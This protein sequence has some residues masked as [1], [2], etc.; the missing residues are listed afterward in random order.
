VKDETFILIIQKR[1]TQ[2]LTFSIHSDLAQEGFIT[3]DHLL[4]EDVLAMA[5]VLFHL[6]DAPMHAEITNTLNPSNSLSPCRMC[7]LQVTQKV[8]KESIEFVRDFLALDEN[9]LKVFF[10]LI[11]LTVCCARSNLP[12]LSCQFMP[13]PRNWANT[14]LQSHQLWM[15]GQKRH[16]K[17]LY[18]DMV[19]QYGLRDHINDYF[20][21]KVQVAH[22]T[23]PPHEV[24]ALVQQLDEDL[25][26]RLFNPML[27][28]KGGSLCIIN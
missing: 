15:S 21:K 5:V 26:D 18:E 16:T 2:M 10:C 13:P 23:Q 20:I 27:R 12:T 9:G 22:D 1:T 8:Q 4:G 7:D 24:A 14:I 6:G 28:L 3:Y 17:T 11:F 25:G 19:R